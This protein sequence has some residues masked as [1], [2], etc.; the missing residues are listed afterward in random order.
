MS[1]R[2]TARHATTWLSSLVIL[3]NFVSIITAL[4][5]GRLF[6]IINI[7]PYVEIWLFLRYNKNALQ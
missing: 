3:I 7:T 1:G 5:M 6:S 4:N 2:E